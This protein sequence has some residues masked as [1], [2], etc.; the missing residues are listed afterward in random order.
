MEYFELQKEDLNKQ[1]NWMVLRHGKETA[2]YEHELAV[3][4]KRLQAM[5]AQAQ[6]LREFNPTAETALQSSS[7]SNTLEEDRLRGELDKHRIE[8]EHLKADSE[9]KIRELTHTNNKLSGEMTSQS[10]KITRLERT[11]QDKSVKIAKFQDKIQSLNEEVRRLEDEAVQKEAATSSDQSRMRN[12][13]QSVIDDRSSTVENL[14]QKI[15]SSEGAYERLR[16]DYNDSKRNLN[17]EKDLLQNKITQIQQ[18]SDRMQSDLERDNNELKIIISSRDKEVV[19]SREL[20]ITSDTETAR[21]RQ[22][23]D[24]MEKEVRVL[25]EQTSSLLDRDQQLRSEIQIIKIEWNKTELALKHNEKVK[26]RMGDDLDTLR[27]RLTA[28]SR[29]SKHRHGDELLPLAINYS[30]G[31]TGA[32]GSHRKRHSSVAD[33]EP[34]WSPT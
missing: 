2:S 27:R 13:L 17:I 14:T 21:W 5:D 25:S 20:M 19:K 1:L 12:E 9:Q 30:G 11:C 29:V 32:H 26:R 24:V 8:G 15:K 6:L 23:C 10:E 4:E 28:A 33:S 18:E 31:S 3:K 34:L 7:I 22:K 16:H